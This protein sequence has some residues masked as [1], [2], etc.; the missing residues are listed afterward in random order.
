M[1]S[2]FLFNIILEAIINKDFLKE[3][4]KRLEKEKIK[5][6]L[7]EDHHCLYCL[8]KIPIPQI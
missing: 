5:L 4:L 3:K 7:F 1:V 2:S 8:Q 6:H